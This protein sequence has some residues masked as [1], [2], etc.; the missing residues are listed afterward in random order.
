MPSDVLLHPHTLYGSRMLTENPAWKLRKKKLG[1][2]VTPENVRSSFSV[3]YTKSLSREPIGCI[4][5]IVEQLNFG[6][7]GHI[8]SEPDEQLQYDLWNKINA[9]ANQE[10]EVLSYTDRDIMV[11]RKWLW[12]TV[13]QNF[14]KKKKLL[15]ITCL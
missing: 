11:D 2:L 5:W 6:D 10:K 3:M 4:P 8:V 9:R 15:I 14:K 12:I 13:T 7:S 1:L